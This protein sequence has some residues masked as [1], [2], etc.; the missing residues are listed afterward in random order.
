MASIFESTQA[1][2][3][4][5]YKQRH[6]GY[7]DF[8]EVTT[9]VISS[10]EALARYLAGTANAYYVI[11][12]NA[13]AVSN[14]NWP[15]LNDWRNAN[16]PGIDGMPCYAREILF[17]CDQNAWVRVIS[18]NPVYTRLISQG[19]SAGYIAS[20]NISQYITEVEQYIPAN[21]FI[22][23]FPTLAHGIVF[24]ADTIQGTLDIWLEG[25]VEGDD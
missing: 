21:E 18:L 7:R 20:L 4:K 8:T 12:T 13:R 25:N 24:R 5:K 14:Y 11:G 15:H 6:Y 3:D 17:L 1:S 9:L 19:K 22:R 10:A 16:I 23:L 2:F